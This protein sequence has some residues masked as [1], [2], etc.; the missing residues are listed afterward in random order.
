MGTYYLALSIRRLFLFIFS[1]VILYFPYFKLVTLKTLVILCNSLK[2]E[3][4][5]FRNI[6]KN[7]S[8]YCVISLANFHLS[9]YSCWL[10]DL[11]SKWQWGWSWHCFDTDLTAFIVQ[12]KLFLRYLDCIYM[13]KAERSVLKQGQL[14]PRFHSWPG[15]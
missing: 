5:A 9:F 8:L 14:Q 11:A 10:S 15:N 3:G 4:R 2:K 6:R 7:I 12:M 13:R 1:I